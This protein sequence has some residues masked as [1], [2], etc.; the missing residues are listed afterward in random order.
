VP[1]KYIMAIGWRQAKS[2]AFVDKGSNP[3]NI[4][5]S[6]TTTTKGDETEAKAKA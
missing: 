1:E 5:N 2:T 3:R 4:I 6:T